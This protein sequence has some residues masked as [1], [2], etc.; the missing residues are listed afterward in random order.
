M[1]CAILSLLEVN[2]APVTPPHSSLV[3][4]HSSLLFVLCLAVMLGASDVLVRGLDRVGGRLS[5]SEGLLGLLTALG[6]DAPE[7]AA[8]VAALHAGA[9]DVGL[10]VVLGSNL[11]NLAAL[12]GL[13]AVLAGHVRVRREGLLLDGGVALA[14][15]LVVALLLFR[16]T[17]PLFA[18]LLLAVLLIPYV[19]VLGLSPRRLMRL[20]LPGRLARLLAIAVSEVDRETAEDP[21]VGE[22]AIHA[23][24]PTRGSWLVVWLIPVALAVIVAGSVGLVD[25]ALTLARAIGAPRPLVGIVLLAG[26]TSLPNAY[27]AARLAL[28]GRGAAVVSE[29][30]NSN[31]INALAGIALPALVFGVSAIAAVTV[32]EVGWL[33]GMTALVLALLS[34]RRGLTRRGG[35]AVILL[36][37]LFVAIQVAITHT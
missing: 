37:L 14:A 16:F 35:V 34:R 19:V 10:G 6:A 4:N 13:G 30:L 9:R 25:T 33:L 32:F 15:T 31:T 18:L 36:Y 2:L 3:T 20:R 28:Q 1:P 8:A 17:P 12:L 29:T 26:L 22:A 27:A 5:L 23:A 21:R 24:S 7:I 11:F